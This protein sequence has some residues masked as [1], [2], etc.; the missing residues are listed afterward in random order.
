M[1]LHHHQCALIVGYCLVFVTRTAT[2]F[3]GVKS[4]LHR[5][6]HAHSHLTAVTTKTTTLT[7]ETTWNVR[8]V[9]RGLTSA[10]GK[11]LDPL[12]Y[13]FE[14]HFVEEEG[15]EPPQGTLALMP[16]T[17]TTTS[18]LTITK[19]RWILSEDP[20]DRKDGLWVWGLFREPLYPFLLLT[21]QTDTLVL[22]NNDDNDSL[23]PMQLYAQ[24]NHRRDEHGNAVLAES[25]DLCWRVME[26]MNADPFGGAKVDLYENVVIG[27]IALQPK[28]S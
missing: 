28:Q 4:P 8:C 2:A 14:C 7:E 20:N 23:P 15:Y 13:A 12:V 10:K 25:T 22:N 21:L 9:F 24:I 5:R 18:S 3:V 16:T 27:S 26:T 19:S 17:N 6:R 1:L 11:K